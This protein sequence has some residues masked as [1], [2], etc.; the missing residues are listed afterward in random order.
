MKMWQYC[1]YLLLPLVLAQDASFHVD[2][3]LT[4]SVV[5]AIVL[6]SVILL[7]CIIGWNAYWRYYYTDHDS[8]DYMRFRV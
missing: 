3:A 6:L 7:C 1:I 2:D 4:L 8:L 5:A